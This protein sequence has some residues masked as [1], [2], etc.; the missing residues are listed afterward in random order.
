MDRAS[1]LELVARLRG[2]DAEAFD[3]IHATFNARLFN[4]LAR[5]ANR[6]DVAEDLLEETWLRLVTH[7][8]RLRADTRL[9]PWLF[10]VA[11]HLHVSYCRTR[12]LEDAHAAGMLGL[13]PAGRRE[14]SALDA[15]QWSEAERRTSRAL[16][17]L[18]I[19]YREA[20]LLVGVEEL[21]AHE[22]AAICGVSAAAMRQ[23]IS[24]ARPLLAERLEGTDIPGLALL[25]E[26]TI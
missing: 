19:R 22:A 20:L 17:A 23:R 21:P 2:G 16:A 7:A 18:P 1:E 11:R 9:G 26:V 15:A 5:L 6:R 3:L 14:P 25:K 10:T 4:F 13:W 24:R 8:G 12:L